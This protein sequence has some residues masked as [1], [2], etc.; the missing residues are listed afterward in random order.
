MIDLLDIAPSGAPAVPTSN[1]ATGAADSAD[2]TNPF[3]S[4][5]KASDGAGL[6]HSYPGPQPHAEDCNDSFSASNINLTHPSLPHMPMDF[7]V[8]PRSLTHPMCSPDH[9]LDRS[10]PTALPEGP[11]SPSLGSLSSQHSDPSVPFRDSVNRSP[12]LNSCVPVPEDQMSVSPPSSSFCLSPPPAVTS[13]PA[14]NAD[15]ALREPSPQKPV[16]AAKQPLVAVKQP[17]LELRQTSFEESRGGI[18]VATIVCSDLSVS[19]VEEGRRSTDSAPSADPNPSFMQESKE[20][21]KLAVVGTDRGTSPSQVPLPTS[22][23]VSRRQTPNSLDLNTT[24][25]SKAEASGQGA[26]KELFSAPQLSCSIDAPMIATTH[27]QDTNMPV[28][29]AEDTAAA[30]GEDLFAAPAPLQAS[31]L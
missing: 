20:P 24:P 26:F 12:P 14:P 2:L 22:P 21:S 8:S 9:S 19:I 17:S 29:E 10:Q 23:I 16:D 4:T 28:L 7:P 3:R 31:S 27:A 18:Q 6:S 11:R 1:G 30:G 25:N 5:P 15:E 13:A